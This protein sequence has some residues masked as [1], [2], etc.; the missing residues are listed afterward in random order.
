MLKFDRDR[1]RDREVGDSE[2]SIF[3][4]ETPAPP[5]AVN[6]ESVQDFPTLEGA[7]PSS[8]L[9]VTVTNNGTGHTNS[10]IAQR[11][12]LKS[13]LNVTSAVAPGGKPNWNAK[14][15]GAS[16]MDEE[17]PALGGPSRSSSS[18]TSHV[19]TTSN[20][21]Q[22]PTSFINFTTSRQQPAAQS[23]VPTG[24]NHP[25]N[26]RPN[27]FVDDEFP[28]L[29]IPSGPNGR[30]WAGSA[31]GVKM[32]MKPVPRVK[33]VA[34]APNLGGR[35]VEVDT[36]DDLHFVPLS[37]SRARR[38]SLSEKFDIK[39][40]DAVETNTTNKDK[41]KKKKKRDKDD[42]SN[43]MPLNAAAIF[44]GGSVRQIET[45]PARNMDDE[46]PSLEPLRTSLPTGPSRRLY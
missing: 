43:N 41:L 20:S 3:R 19:S 6:T 38:D 32:K 44:T 14:V 42:N 8:V 7:A 10:S 45:G 22:Q 11:L 30:V 9:P 25:R 37:V 1:D 5:K 12:A 28:T 35:K 2:D 33:K 29:D 18:S 26:P 31:P 40:E 21:Y 15:S 16:K 23:H 34:A 24:N 17:F 27:G 46:F 39:D 4:R 13:G 36:S